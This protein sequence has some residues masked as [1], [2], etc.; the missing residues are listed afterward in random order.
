[1]PLFT[2]EITVKAPD[3]KDKEFTGQIKIR[4][5]DDIYDYEIIPVTLK[6]PKSKTVR[7]N[8]FEKLLSFFPILEQILSTNQLFNR[9]LNL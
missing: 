5:K 2:V 1:M 4:N 7:I 6:T 3:E 9:L 8:Y